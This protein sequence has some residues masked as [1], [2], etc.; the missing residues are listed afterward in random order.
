MGVKA[1][2]KMKGQQK[3]KNGK[4]HLK[5]DVVKFPFEA[6]QMI[7]DFKNLLKANQQISKLLRFKYVLLK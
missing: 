1:S 2:L 5:M 6:D 3:N 4:T 7:V